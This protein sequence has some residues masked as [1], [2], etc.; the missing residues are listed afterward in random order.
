MQVTRAVQG[1]Q[2]PGQ[3]GADL[4]QLVLL[5]VTVLLQPLPQGRPRQELEQEPGAPVVPACRQ[6][7]H[8]AGDRELAREASLPLEGLRQQG[9]PGGVGVQALE[10]DL[11]PRGELAPG[12][13]QPRAVDAARGARAELLEDL[14]A[15]HAAGGAGRAI[16]GGRVAG[17]G[18]LGLGGRGPRRGGDRKMAQSRESSETPSL[19]PGGGRV[20]MPPGR[21][22]SR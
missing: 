22:S 13:G 21:R 9:V 7:A 6:A 12:G 15:G 18:A 10:S 4:S 3:P 20:K 5:E 16:G 17:H 19:I 8:Q 2:C 1:V 14:E 11:R